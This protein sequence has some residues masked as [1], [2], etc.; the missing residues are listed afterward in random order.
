MSK[1]LVTDPC[2]II[3]NDE[4]DRL[5]SVA[6]NSE[7]DWLVAFNKEVQGY[8]DENIKMLLVSQ[9]ENGDGSI[10]GRTERGQFYEIG[11]D[12]GMVCIA[13]IINYSFD[14]GPFGALVSSFSEAKKIY[15]RAKQI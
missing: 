13:E 14:V 5:V 8:S 4:W 11:V 2:Y 15:S 1:F 6:D 9:T 7:G 3:S 10:S 12:A